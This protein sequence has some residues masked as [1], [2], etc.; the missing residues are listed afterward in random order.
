M[1]LQIL[2]RKFLKSEEEW[3]R[4]RWEENKRKI[5]GEKKENEV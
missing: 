3:E 4:K 1:N 5:E 2:E